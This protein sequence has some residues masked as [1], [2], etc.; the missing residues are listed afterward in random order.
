VIG[1]VAPPDREVAGDGIE[2]AVAIAPVMSAGSVG[3]VVKLTAI[4][5]GDSASPITATSAVWIIGPDTVVFEFSAVFFPAGFPLTV[6]V[7][8]SGCGVTGAGAR[9]FCKVLAKLLGPG[10]ADG[11]GRADLLE[12]SDDDASA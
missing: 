8:S 9:A 3:T 11:K 1:T 2:P 10:P 4:T 12:E 7:A 5:K 6:T